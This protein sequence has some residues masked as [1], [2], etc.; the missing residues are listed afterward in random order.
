[1]S[2]KRRVADR[3]RTR[4]TPIDQT[5]KLKAIADSLYELLFSFISGDVGSVKGKVQDSSGYI[6]KKVRE[7]FFLSHVV[8]LVMKTC[9]IHRPVLNQIC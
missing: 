6:S 2:Q 9:K 3:F 5:S 7:L 1:M 8:I 4:C